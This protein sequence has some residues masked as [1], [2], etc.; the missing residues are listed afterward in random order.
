M[1]C[2]EILP[3]SLRTFS[4]RCK[5]ACVCLDTLEF[6][7]NWSKNAVLVVLLTFWITED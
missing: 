3:F 6:S 4:L 5:F 1:F 2:A 7:E